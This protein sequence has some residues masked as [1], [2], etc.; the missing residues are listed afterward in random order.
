M[1]ELLKKVIK[2][3]LTIANGEDYDVGKITGIGGIAIFFTLTIADFCIHKHFDAIAFGTG[4]GG[5]I[6]GLG[7]ALMLKHKTEPQ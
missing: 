3:C 5:M 2:D 1:M 6:A 7:A 4:F